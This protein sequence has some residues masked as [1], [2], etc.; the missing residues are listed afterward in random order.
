MTRGEPEVLTPPANAPS[1]V[2]QA[3]SLS[4]LALPPSPRP[5]GRQ[6][7]A[8]SPVP[9]GAVTSAESCMSQAQCLLEFSHQ[10]AT[11]VTVETPGV[12]CLLR[13]AEGRP[14]S[15][16]LYPP[17]ISRHRNW[18]AKKGGPRELQLPHSRP[19]EMTPGV[20]PGPSSRTVFPRCL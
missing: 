14:G 10:G 20:R 6:P 7:R 9:C 12:Q 18:A 4:I 17:P 5:E 3:G 19:G 1:L 16:S 2:Y 13:E 15:L 8:W 11:C